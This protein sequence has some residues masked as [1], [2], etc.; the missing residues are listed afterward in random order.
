[1]KQPRPLSLRALSIG[2]A[3]VLLGAAALA[4]PPPAS[5]QDINAD[6]Q[7]LQRDLADLQRYVYSGQGGA[8]GQPLSGGATAADGAPIPS[9]VAGRLQ[10]QIQNMENRLR[11]MTGRFEELQFE[12][13]KM[14]RRLDTALGDI[15]YRLTQLEG[16]TPTARAPG[17]TSR[18]GVG[19]S[20]QGGATQVIP[21]ETVGGTTVISSEGTSVTSSGGTLGT[22]IF[23]E[24]GNVTGLA[25]DPGATTGSGP[26]GQSGQVGEAPPPVVVEQ[27]G[28]I[29]GADV[30]S[31]AESAPAELPQGAKPL[32][33][34]SLALMRRGEYDQAEASL[35]VFLDRHPEDD[36]VSAALYW[37]G[38]THYVRD[39]YRD[40]AFSFVDVYSKYPK[41]SKAP[42][43]LLKLGMS[44]HALGNV[45]EACT[46]FATLKTEYP[47]ARRAVLKL[48]EDRAAQYG[49]P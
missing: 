3:A 28:A 24:Q 15:D 46:A 12:I 35:R 1:M 21:T 41:S 45:N 6:L 9:D 34:H 13:T 4:V 2:V 39:S 20:G 7:R 49:C 27:A 48:A 37:L 44:L 47:D 33:D 11:E 19:T 42:D 38:E 32:Y 18:V 14:S 16:G 29:E 8:V 36:L 40:A 17:S 25:V 31:A 23:D 5:A 10:V 43:S 26:V 30:A 22:L